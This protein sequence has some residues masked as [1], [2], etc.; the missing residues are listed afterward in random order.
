LILPF[1]EQKALYDAYN[2]GE[3]WN[4]PN[5]GKLAHQIGSIYLRSGLEPDQA[6]TTSFVAVVGPETAWPGATPLSFNDL[7]EAGV[8]RSWWL[9]SLMES[10]SGWSPG[11]CV[12]TT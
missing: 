9:R 11:I 3:P 6:H 1:L 10:S 4:G 8:I 5:N 12:S 2:F 7:A